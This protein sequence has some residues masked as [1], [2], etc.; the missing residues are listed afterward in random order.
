MFILIIFIVGLMFLLSPTFRCLFLNIHKYIYNRLKDIYKYIRY[1]KYNLCKN[2]GMLTFVASEKQAFGS[3]KTLMC[4][5]YL[6]SYYKKYNDKIIYI[7][8]EN[9]KYVKKIQKL[10]VFSNLEIKDVPSIWFD[11]LEMLEEWGDKKQKLEEENPDCVFKLIILTDELGAILNSRSFK[12]NITNSNINTILQ[13]RHLDICLWVSSTQRFNFIDC[14][15]RN[16]IDKAI[17]CRLLGFLDFKK[18]LLYTELFLAQDLENVGSVGD[19]K[20]K[21]LRKKCFYISDDD[22]IRYDTKHMIS[23]LIHKQRTGDLISDE[24]YL[25]N[26]QLDNQSINIKI[27]KNKKRKF[28]K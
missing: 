12:S 15:Y 23:D 4:V 11:S 9:G 26:I 10:V 6:Y 1:K 25:K 19:N 7:K 17:T 16:T 28:L 24:E 13:Q 20:I 8:N 21:P 22:Y 3:G 5:K 2:E 14:L 27:S 18:R